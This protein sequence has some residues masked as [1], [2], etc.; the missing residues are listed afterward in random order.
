MNLVLIGFMGAGKTT[1]GRRVARRLGYH[2]L[3]MDEHIE[4]EENR[5]IPEIFAQHGEAAFRHLETQLLKRLR[6][7]QNTVIASGGGVVVK[8]GNLDMIKGLGKVFY[9]KAAVEDIIERVTR[10]QHRPLLNEENPEEKVKALLAQRAP[11]YEQADC[12]I[13]TKN[14]SLHRITSLIIQNL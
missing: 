10:S 6:P 14:L 9:L 13:E 8:D 2:F 11:L 7:V 12:I 1:I 4:R 3:D 5:K